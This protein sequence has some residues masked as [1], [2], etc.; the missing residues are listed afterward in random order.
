MFYLLYKSSTS[1]CFELD[2]REAYYS[3]SVYTILLDGEKVREGNTNVFSLFG[4]KPDTEYELTLV[5]ADDQET[6]RFKTLEET[7]ALNVRDF[8]AVGDGVKDDTDAIRTALSFLP[9]G[10][11]L[12]FPAG[13]YLTLPQALK[14]NITIEIGEGAVILGS[15]DREKYPILP[16]EVR[17]MN[18]GEKMI[19][20]AFEGNV[21]E[22]YQ[23][24]FTAAY[25]QN[26]TIIGPGTVD[27]NGG[28]G[29]FW[30]NFK[31]FCWIRVNSPR[32]NLF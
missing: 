12:Y 8:G 9:E 22:M 4:L 3:P 13:T 25:A 11:R 29:D 10:G 14:S 24:L 6:L 21:C 31:N 28:G 18:D 7:C 19:F 20:G 32:P 2:N 17:N 27:G 5:S 26:I 30:T 15:P 1:A 23:S 16:G